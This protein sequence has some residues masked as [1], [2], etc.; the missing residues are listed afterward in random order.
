MQLDAR[1]YVAGGRTPIGAVLIRRLQGT[2]YTGLVGLPP[3]EP[4]LTDGRAVASFFLRQRPEYV[5]FAAGKSGGIHANLEHPADLMHDN[6]LATTHV[7]ASARSHGV[8]KL[9]F[10]ASSCSYP[11][12]CRQPMAVADLMTGPLEPSSAAYATAKLAGLALC[13]AYRQQYGSHFVA[14]VP[15]DVFGPDDD[16]HPE[17]SHVIP[18][19]IRRLHDAKQRGDA[20]FTV[21]GTGTP[22]R[23][24]LY[25]ADLADACIFALDRYDGAEPINLGGGTDLSIAEAA[26]EV[27]AVVGYRG[28]LSFDRS[29]PDGAPLKRLDA[30]HLHQLGWRPH[31][32]FRDG[33]TQT[34]RWFLNHYRGSPHAA[35]IAV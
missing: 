25:S 20:V 9:L 4:D 18:A 3:E 27:A 28:R 7:L 13:R 16:F 10:L 8:A 15:A 17:R 26:A 24:F 2:G 33:L 1:I 12:L 34:Y 23:E 14:A 6:L 32:H 31:T 35:S 29:R 30:T 21:W 19:L 22:R 5:F 11:R